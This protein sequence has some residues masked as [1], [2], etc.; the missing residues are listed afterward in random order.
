MLV[1]INILLTLTILCVMYLIYLEYVYHKNHTSIQ[2][3]I[4]EKVNGVAIPYTLVYATPFEALGR[5][6]FLKDPCIRADVMHK[7]NY[8]FAKIL[9]I[10]NYQFTAYYKRITK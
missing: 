8:D 3:I 6:P 10:N 5:E 1:L 9:T 4:Y 7:N 2:E